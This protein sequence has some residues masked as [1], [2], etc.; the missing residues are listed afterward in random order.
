[1]IDRSLNYGRDIIER[2]IRCSVPFSTVL[3]V[4]AGTGSD[5]ESASSVNPS[6]RLIAIEM[7]DSNVI[8]LRRRT[9]E[10]YKLD[11]EKE[12]LPI[13]DES[14]DIVIANQ[15]L[16]H[17]KEL[18]WILHELSRV[19][20]I[21]G[22]LIVGVPNLA[23]LHNRL[24]LLFGRQPTSIKTCSAHVRGFTKRDLMN[25]LT[26][27]FPGGYEIAGFRGSNFYPFP[28]FMAKP[29]ARMFPTMAWG[30]FFRLV[31]NM[32]YGEEFLAYLSEQRIETNYF[33]GAQ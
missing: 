31:K 11:I 29:L 6:V 5:L 27:C 24:L 20:R 33:R 12:R 28:P 22:S 2:V 10:V 18:F 7:E 21:G 9:V 4:G 14:I 30:I 23:S 17:T 26:A 8:N 15:V 16:E 3:D 25:F 19:L 32:R 1:M 13:E